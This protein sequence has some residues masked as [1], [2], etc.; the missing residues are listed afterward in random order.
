MDRGILDQLW[1]VSSHDNSRL[2]K[3]LYIL[4]GPFETPRSLTS[5]ES[6]SKGLAGESVVQEMSVSGPRINSAVLA[7]G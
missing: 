4:C 2:I 5:E 1:L 6:S 7:V 3:V